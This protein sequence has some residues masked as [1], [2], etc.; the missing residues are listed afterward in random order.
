MRMIL[1]DDE[2][3]IIRGIKKLVDWAA[4]GIEIVGSYE[5]GKSALE[6]IVRLRP[7]LALL[8]ISMPGLSGIEIL[9]ECRK[10]ELKTRVIFISGFQDFE[11]A[12]EAIRYGAMDY[13]LKPVIKEELLSSV[14]KC[15]EAGRQ[16][17]EDVSLASPESPE[18]DYSRL[19]ELEETD[20]VPVLAELLFDEKEDEQMQRLT[21]FSFLS[22]LEE[23]LT[24]HRLGIT[25]TRDGYTV[26]VLKGMAKAEMG[27]QLEQLRAA[28]YAAVRHPVG[29]IVGRRINSL[30]EIPGAYQQCMEMMGYFFFAD[31]MKVPVLRV[32]EKVFSYPADAG[33]LQEAREHLMDAVI[34]QDGEAFDKA[35]DWFAQMIC[36]L[37][38]GKKE[39]ACYYFCSSL[40]MMEERFI[41]LSLKGCEPE[42]K[43]LLEKGRSC[44]TFGGLRTL[45][46]EKYGQ[47]MEQLKHT[48][49]GNEK[50]AVLK[51]KEYIEKHYRENLTLQ[52]LADVVHMNPYYFSAFFKKNAGENFK[53]YVNKVRLRHAVSLLLNTDMK[54]Y[55]I[56][57][58]VGFGDPRNF[59]E[60]FQKVYHETPNGYRKR[61]GG[62]G[63]T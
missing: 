43:A 24:E 18:A 44:K 10:M 62:K 57:G 40:R 36:F 21:R 6:G 61:V 22:F 56:A 17:R 41:A 11:Y 50:Q 16:S 47:Y 28:A 4:M 35:Y 51:A 32:G 59:T 33:R 31:Q 37:S 7:D 15:M 19:V 46:R 38:D 1:A 30:G 12:K 14:G 45:F 13:L 55:E 5:D 20:Y 3:V 48:V 23:Y 58:E 42:M 34:A 54:A 8:D 26:I 27:G 2:P 25:F 9:R 52:V 53:D 49:A 29:L 60:S 39:D 63:M